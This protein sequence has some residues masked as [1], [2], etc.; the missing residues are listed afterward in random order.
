MGMFPKPVPC[1]DIDL[2]LEN[3]YGSDLLPPPSQTTARENVESVFREQK[4]KGCDPLQVSFLVDC[5]SS[6]HRMKCTK[7]FSP[8]ITCSRG[9]GHWVTSRKRRLTK[10]EMM[11][12]Q[13][14]EPEN[15][16]VVVSDTQLGKQIGNSMSVNVLERV[17]L[18][19]LPAGGLVGHGAMLDR[20][21]RGTP[22][23]SL[24]ARDPTQRA[25]CLSTQKETFQKLIPCEDWSLSLNAKQPESKC[26]QEVVR[27]PMLLPLVE[28]AASQWCRPFNGRFAK[29]RHGECGEQFHETRLSGNSSRCDETTETRSI[30]QQYLGAIL[31]APNC[32]VMVALLRHLPASPKR[33]VLRMLPKN[34]R[35]ALEDYL[36]SRAILQAS[37]C[38]SMVA[39]LRQLPASQKRRVLTMLPKKV[40]RALEDYL[41]ARPK[42]SLITVRHPVSQPP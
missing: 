29:S 16:K 14:I 41:R 21:Q 34:L 24:L 19:A 23:T 32:R 36:R 12:L 28:D 30:P 17:L 35:R 10:A 33:R 13:G 31:H 38:C 40:R 2:F 42:H 15:F 26:Q 4:S 6:P 7:G 20:W 5:D 27:G 3:T 1:P 8:C 37:N 9:S 18:R 11:R 22:P 39:R 25:H